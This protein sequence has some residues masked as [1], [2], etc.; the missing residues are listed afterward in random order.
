MQKTLKWLVIVC[1]LS[2][3][4]GFTQSVA[5]SE[6]TVDIKAATWHPV[7]HRLTDDAFKLYGTE[8]EKRTNGKV[9][10]T[11]LL[12]G[13]LVNPF[14]AYDGLKSGICDWTLFMT[15]IKPNEFVVTNAVNLPF[16]AD[17]ASHAAAMLVRMYDEIPEMKKEYKKFI[18]VAFFSTAAV[19]LHTTKKAPQNLAE[20]KGLKTG[21]PGPMLLQ[22]IKG[23]GGSAQQLK[24]GDM[25]IAVQ[26][27]MV[28]GTLFPDAPLRSYKLTE[29]IS[30]HTMMDVAVD[31]F[32]VGINK[33]KWE[34]L[35]PE[36]KKAFE[37]IRPSAS[38]LFGA[39]LTNEAAWV[40]EELKAR[41]DEYY[42]LP[43]SE[44]ALWKETL[45]P[46]YEKWV[47]KANKKGMDGEAILSKI[48]TIAAETRTSPYKPDSW[49]GRAGKKE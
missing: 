32:A 5:I 39:T 31:A 19:N 7:T 10:F 44:K 14:N 6:E 11:W 37:D 35:S 40:N 2:L 16:M 42:Y 45:Q 15:A 8:L 21:T 49:W 33:D 36:V 41:G 13:S 17:S 25:Y 9:K 30:H 27:G 34:E 20:F 22:I 3:T 38:A 26:K 1:C 43:E 46:M 28:E 48:Q 29:L 24:P 12:G 4:V 18:P 23:L 47:A